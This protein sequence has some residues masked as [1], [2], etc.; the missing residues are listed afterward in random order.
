MYE[1]TNT[2]SLSTLFV[3]IQKIDT[4][5]VRIYSVLVNTLFNVLIDK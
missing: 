3:F 1:K 4:G 5:F 2:Q